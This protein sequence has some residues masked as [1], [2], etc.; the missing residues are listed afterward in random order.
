[1]STSVKYF[2]SAMTD[3][4]VLNGVA[5]SLIGVLD[6][7]LVNGFQLRTVASISIA[8][9]VAT[10]TVAA[11]H[12]YEVDSVVEIAGA[13]PG[14]L[15][16]QK[17]VLSAT[18]TTFTFATAEA[19][20]S[21]TGTISAKLASAGWEKPFSDTNLAAYR[22]PNVEGTR[23]FLRV[24][25]A[26]AQNARVI[27]CENMTD[28]NTITNAF[29]TETQLAGGIWW[30]NASTTAV[31]ARTWA[32][33]ADD[34]AFYVWVNSGVTG[35]WGEGFIYGFGDFNSFKSGDA[36][37]CFIS[38]TNTNIV[39]TTAGNTQ[40]LT[41]TWLAGTTL[42]TQ[43]AARSFTALGGSVQTSRKMESFGTADAYSGN[44]ASVVYPN[45][46]DNSLLLS[47]T[48]IT[49]T[50]GPNMRGVLPGLL[51]VPH[52]LGVAT[53]S[54]RQKVDGQGVYAGRKL[55]AFNNVGAI[56]GT[57]TTQAAGFIDITGPWR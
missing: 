30:P 42:T 25:D 20:G 48:L 22:S 41:H 3:A 44:T 13:T 57:T 32:V 38:G 31:T 47:R 35:V 52:A 21:A 28:I 23:M 12:G 55:M 50:V 16:G 45:T 15:N 40:T 9:S 19:D 1:M 54:T 4:P 5:G 26:T 7:C 34:R 39:T 2:H 33:V 6:A 51:F 43:Y 14:T 46:S 10:A 49:E 53:F 27:G 36:Y 11:G 17:R 18:S 29:P 37:S 24:N 8:S 56:A